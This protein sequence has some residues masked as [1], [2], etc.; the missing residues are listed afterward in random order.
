MNLKATHNCYDLTISIARY[1]GG[2]RNRGVYIGYLQL[3][4]GRWEVAKWY[5]EETPQIAKWK[6]KSAANLV[7]R[8]DAALEGV[9]R[10]DYISDAI[11]DAK[12]R[13]LPYPIG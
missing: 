4:K 2:D 13:Y 8:I 7:R 6:D 12:V 11:T 5:H 3:R 10:K 9:K 1:R